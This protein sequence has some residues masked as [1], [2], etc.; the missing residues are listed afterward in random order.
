M[1]KKPFSFTGRIRRTEYGVSLIIATLLNAL[2]VGFGLIITIPFM[3]AQ[4]AKRSHDI[5]NSGWFILLPIYNP[6]ILLFQDGQNN[7]NQYGENPKNLIG[8]NEKKYN[9][10]AVNQD[11][12]EKTSQEMIIPITCP[13]CKNPNSK[14][15]RICEW[16]GNQIV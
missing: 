10:S 14:K 2:T 15:I 5:G 1:F 7:S 3:L 12:Y 6:F 11:N 13:H 8:E 4:G 9:S 16:C